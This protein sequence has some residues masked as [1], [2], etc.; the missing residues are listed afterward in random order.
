MSIISKIP[1]ENILF[2]DIE[3]VAQYKD[4]DSS[5]QEYRKLW[6]KKSERLQT[7]DK[8]SADIYSSAAMLAEF[9]KIICI[10]VGIFD[11][12]FCFRVKAFYGDDESQLLKNFA[13]M[14]SKYF[15]TERHFLCAHNGKEFDYP[16][17]ARRMLLNSLPIPEILDTR[18][19]KPWEIRHLDTLELWRFGDYKHYTPLNLLTYIFNIPTPKDDIDGS[20]VNSIYW[21]ENNLERIVTYC[22]KDVV[23]LARLYLKYRGTHVLPDENVIF[24]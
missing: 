1:L 13:D 18:G 5:P 16:Y 7:E 15:N 10:A 17:I 19:L 12:Q 6:D 22:K 20:Q 4:Y 3:T 9:G 2:V 11:K 21:N 23:A 24:I 8:N 14:L